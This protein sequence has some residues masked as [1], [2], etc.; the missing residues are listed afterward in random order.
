MSRSCVWNRSRA[1]VR[2]SSP[3]R[4]VRADAAQD[5]VVG[6]AGAVRR[7]GRCPRPPRRTSRAP[8]VRLLLRAAG[9]AEERVPADDR[10][11]RAA[12]S[13]SLFHAFPAHAS[14]EGVTPS[15]QAVPAGPISFFQIGTR[16]FRASMISSAQRNAGARWGAPTATT[17]LASP[18]GSLPRRWKTAMSGTPCLRGDRGDDLPQLAFGHRPIGLVLDARDFAALVLVAHTPEEQDHRAVRAARDVRARGI[19]VQR[20]VGDFDEHGSRVIRRSPAG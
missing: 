9:L 5:F 16:S 2:A 13:H 6:A 8:A 11:A 18:T 10:A 12:D 17:R 20:G 19:G 3:A 7:A 15:C 1:T 14:A 4:E